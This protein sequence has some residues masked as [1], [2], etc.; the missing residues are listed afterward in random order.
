ML[1][2]P[3]SRR[4]RHWPMLGA[5]AEPRSIGQCCILADAAAD[6]PRRR[7]TQSPALHHWQ[8]KRPTQTLC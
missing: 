4:L 5:A 8:T 6:A 7:L 2:T 3:A 1:L